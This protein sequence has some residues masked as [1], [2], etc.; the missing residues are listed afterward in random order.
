MR[1]SN[2]KE[3]SRD[4]QIVFLKKISFFND[5]D[6]H[7]LRQFL[8]VSR[9]L[10]VPRNTRIIRER[11][12]ERIFFILVKGEVSVFKT[13]EDNGSIIELTRLKTGDC[14]GEMSLVMEGRR[15]AGVKT[16]Q[17]TYLLM[18]EPDIISTS[19]VF[20]QLKF[21]KRFCEIMAS[22]LMATNAK[23]AGRELG[24]GEE[25]PE[26][27]GRKEEAEKVAVLADVRPA[28]LTPEPPRQISSETTAVDLGKMPPMPTEEDRRGK[29]Q[30]HRLVSPTRPLPICPIIGRHLR[31]FWSSGNSSNTRRLAE[32]IGMDP[33]ISARV[34][35][36]A[37]SSFFRRSS[38]VVSIPH[39]MITMGLDQVRA[40]IQEEILEVTTQQ[41]IFFSGFKQVYRAFWHHAVV[42]GRIGELLQQIIRAHSSLDLYMAGLLHDIGML[43]LDPLNPNFYAQSL[44]DDSE[45]SRR[46]TASELRYI[47]ID[48]GTAGVWLGEKMGL[49]E[50][51]LAIIQ[52]HHDPQGA[53]EHLLAVA[54]IHLADLFAARRGICLGS[55]DPD[56]LNPLDSF[57][58]GILQDQHRPFMEVN[59]VDFINDFEDELD[60]NWNSIAEL[61]S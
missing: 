60:K 40:L 13:S 33:V 47:G 12:S 25:S 18:V 31:L 23:V 55:P 21:Y 59:I 58:W 38:P 19:N 53:R 45:I 26:Y 36:A 52:H 11:T 37:N 43:G 51:F 57:A 17:Q 20:L 42:V 7:E 4:Q 27:E 48:H 30:L 6:D 24:E 1:G 5:F 10:K 8:S 2:E 28:A 56:T 39:A 41:Q 32:L 22:R 16:T 49:P 50:P 54:I 44:R 34:L 14:F 61:P 46:L 15:T 9:W 35:Q 3:I 29:I